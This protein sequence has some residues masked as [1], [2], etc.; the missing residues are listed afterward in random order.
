[1][2]INVLERK[3]VSPSIGFCTVTDAGPVVSMY[4]DAGHGRRVFESMKR[5][6]Y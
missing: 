6:E 1:V 2:K 3:A 4:R 5:A